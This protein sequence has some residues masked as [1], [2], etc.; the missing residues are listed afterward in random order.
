VTTPAAL[1]DP[2]TGAGRSVIR[3]LEVE[4]IAWLTTVTPDGRPQSS[5]VWFLWADGEILI[6]S[7]LG[8]PRTRNIAANG[9]VS[10]HLNSDAKGDDIVTLEAEARLDPAAPPAAANPAYL[11]KYH[12]LIVENGWT[13]ERFATDYPD[14]IRIRPTR[15]RL[16]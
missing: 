7:R 16:G 15:L 14:P 3:R 6:Y 2:T 1:P 4:L 12:W 13:D 8:A 5:A 9:R 10:V 11:A